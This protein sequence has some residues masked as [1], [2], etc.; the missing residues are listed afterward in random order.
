M[1]ALIRTETL[2]FPGGRLSE[3][4]LVVAL[5]TLIVG[6]LG[7]VAQADIKRMLSFTLVSHIGYM[8][9]G[10][11]VGTRPATRRRSSTSSTTSRC[12]RRSSSRPA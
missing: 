5:L 4:L 8:V 3:V 9:F 7:A 11:A 12:R 2:L 6:I 1:Y 10:I